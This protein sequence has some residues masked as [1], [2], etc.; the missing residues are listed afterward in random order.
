[1]A[2]ANKIDPNLDVDTPKESLD[3]GPDKP[4]KKV[5][6]P[7]GIRGNP[8]SHFGRPSIINTVA[9]FRKLLR[10]DQE[11]DCARPPASY[12]AGVSRLEKNHVVSDSTL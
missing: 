1:M 10:V 7:S 5:D 4:K 11:L 3:P 8:P 12:R 9:F 2:G 6:V